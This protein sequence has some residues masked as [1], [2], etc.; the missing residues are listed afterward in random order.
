MG[1]ELTKVQVEQ[2]F[3]SMEDFFKWALDQ[4]LAFTFCNKEVK[5]SYNAAA[6]RTVPDLGSYQVPEF[7]RL[8]FS[9]KDDVQSTP[10]DGAATSKKK[11]IN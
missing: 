5:L 1:L 3:S 6:V 10:L 2:I 4:R 8:F 7:Y 11:K 9:L